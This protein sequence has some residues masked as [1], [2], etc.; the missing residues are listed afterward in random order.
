MAT[1]NA[2]IIDGTLGD[3]IIDALGGRDTIYATQGHDSV[4]GGANLNDRIIAVLADPTRFADPAT[5]SRTYTITNNHLGSSSGGLDTSFV[6]VERV[7]LELGGTGDF[8]DTID[9]T[10]FTGG[11]ALDLRLGNGNDTVFG[12][13][14]NESIYA[15]GGIN[16][17][18][19]GAGTDSVAADVDFAAGSTVFV[20]GSGNQVQT[21]HNGTIT[22]TILNAEQ[23]LIGSNIDLAF[24]VDGLTHTVDASAYIGA[25]QIVFYDH[26]GNDIFIGSSGSDV[27]ANLYNATVG[28]DIYTGNGGADIFDYTV[29]VNALNNDVITDFDTDDTIDFRF[30]DG[31]SAP[32]QL[33]CNSFI[34]AAAFSGVAGQYRYTISGNQT[35][36]QIDTDGDAA[37]DRTL[38]LSNGTFVI[39]ETFAGSN[40]LRLAGNVIQGTAGPDTLTGTSG[41]DTIING[42]GVDTI[43]AGD[44]DDTIVLNAQVGFGSVLDGGNGFDTLELKTQPTFVSNLGG[45]STSYNVYY[46]TVPSSIEAVRFDSAPGDILSIN[47]LEFQR[48]AAGLT[49]LIGGGGRDLFYDIV[50]SP[51][52]YT[53]PQLTLVNWNADISDLNADYIVLYA[54]SAGNYTLNAREGL[55]A[56]QALIGNVGNDVLNGSSGS[57]ALNGMGGVNQLY[58][59]AGNDTLYAENPTPFG[60]SPTALTYAG[61]TFNGGADIDTLVVGGP[62]NFQGTLTSIER[63]YFEAA[64]AAQAPGQ[65]GFDP[66][67]LT[68]STTTA[69]GLPSDLIL[70]G[71]GTLEINLDAPS[72][73]SAAGYAFV[74]GSTVDL[75]LNGTAGDDEIVGSVGADTINGGDGS[76]F[77]RGNVGDDAIY[78]GDG[79]DLIKGQDGDDLIDGGLGTDRAGYYQANAALGGVTVSL[80]L[81]G[82][83]QYVGSQGWDT[84]VS[85]ENVF[86]TPFADV[87]TGDGGNNWL[88]GSEATIDGNVSAINN[89]L[90]DGQGGNDLLSIG[91]GNHTLIGGS[92]NDTVWFTEHGF[93]ETGITVS[94]ASP[95]TVQATG[96]GDWS[97]TGIENLTGG[98]ANDILTG[99]DGVNV[100]GGGAG[101]DT[102]IGGIGNDVLYG[103]GGIAVDAN[104][105]ITTFA[106]VAAINGTGIGA[107]VAMMPG[108]S[109]NDTLEG[110]EGDDV[111]WGGGGSDTA[112]YASASGA[113]EV[114]LYN[115]GFGEAFGAAGYDQLH[116]IENITGSAFNDS[117]FG[118]AL[119]NVLA[120]GDGVDALR[121]NGGNDAL[122]GGGDDDFINGGNGD[123]FINGGS[124][125]DRA[126]YFQ[127]DAALGGI[128]VSLLLQGSAQYVGSQGWD[129]L[130][131]IENVS[132]TPFADI[133]TGDGAD[134]WLWGS[135]SWNGSVQSATNN[136]TIDGGGGND[137]IE[138]GLGNHLLTGG[139][140]NDTV[141]YSE[142]G[143]AEVGITVSLALQGAAQTTGAG[144]WML[145]GI[146][147]LRGGTGNDQLTGDENANV[148]T[149]GGG[150]DQLVGGAGS[151]QAAY[152]GNAADFAVVSLGGGA[153]Q[154][155]DLNAADG[156]EGVDLILGIEQLLFADQ[157]V[158]LNEAPVA[159]ASSFLT[160]EDTDLGGQVA[161]SDLEN[162]PLT[163]QL[164]TGPTNGTLSF[165]PDGTFN[166]TPGVNFFGADSFTFTA[167]DGN[168]TSNVATAD[169]VIAPVDN[170]AATIGG[171]LT[172]ELTEGINPAAPNGTISGQ[173]SAVDPDGPTS[174]TAGNQAGTWGAFTISA[175]GGWSYE[176]ADNDPFIGALKASDTVTD[177][178]TVTTADG[179]S[180]LV[181]VTIHGANDAAVI[182]GTRTA[183]VGE[184]ALLG[185]TSQV[186]GALTISDIDSPSQFVAA[187]LAGLYGTLTLN[188]S[189]SWTYVL[190]NANPV[191]DGLSN[192]NSLSD[193]FTVFAADGT[194]QQ[195]LITVTGS[196]D[197]RTGTNNADVL[198][199]TT[200]NDTLNGNNGNDT[201]GGGLGN[202]VLN[203]GNGIDTA[204]YA[205]LAAGVTVSLEIST[206]Q[207]TLGGGIDT[208]LSIENLTGTNQ[209]DVLTGNSSNNT[210]IGGDGNDVLQGGAGDDILN[211]GNGID[212]ASYVSAGSAVTVSLAVSASQKTGGAGSDTL[213][214]I[215]NLVGSGFADALT[216][217]STANVLTGG[218]GADRLTGGGGADVL[219]GGLGDDVFSFA[220][221]LDSGPSVLAR[222]IISDFQ[223]AGIA[224]GD[225][226]D[227]SAIDAVPGGRDNAFA[228]IGN[229]GFHNVAGELRF[230]TSTPGYTVVQADTNGDGVADLEI[231][232][233]WADSGTPIIPVSTDFVL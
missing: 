3:D 102:L 71:I 46:P 129:T 192:G 83:A 127:S 216:G 217:N 147:N 120:G 25:A 148:L 50:F 7:T 47:M 84:L 193:S 141:W 175:D 221:L 73:F 100:L 122:Y 211:G 227:L 86:G 22:N 150:N 206:A 168:T 19:A 61:S 116:D 75:I 180:S 155:S 62:V 197:V 176:L 48:A 154:V 104:G 181:T 67:H 81:Q 203:G 173:L 58:G 169:L 23:I 28:D 64:F 70:N 231:A 121:G 101:N 42:G 174:F 218:A 37:A 54:S 4:D 8:G 66:A 20:T 36:I 123:D 214:G 59:N 32:G 15:R 57:D 153:W 110:G 52:N 170:D 230:D 79:N 106:D 41:T 202:D 187:T 60:S 17:I 204:T 38:T 219:F 108:V 209:A 63:I 85:I 33:L 195:V 132:G 89:D 232:L 44:G 29:A 55:A 208:L 35:L 39:A 184:A 53:M 131:N 11:F 69:Q 213:T 107:D 182:G 212:T 98:T 167:S 14:G 228:F 74:P 146:E 163:F 80:L 133:L 158:T 172:G 134:N 201:L 97:L 161:A 49:T 171:Q 157:L 105:V 13:A 78:G 77:L 24:A 95:G 76:D 118:N 93:P 220:A 96:N 5:G 125:N 9:A 156:D 210:L 91:I 119:A 51:G 152:T 233:Q 2:D 160:D 142:N 178:F 115:G 137:L 140:D 87:L 149:G 223:G 166:Y 45:T 26:N 151:D 222:D 165:N 128:T 136:D 31:A 112:S 124:G 43:H 186:A 159:T 99:D 34:G 188:A 226:I 27:F 189:G 30:N 94:L 117:L 6:N 162:A 225:I 138:V 88:S 103:D 183:A 198:S 135:I 92:D 199:G 144:S 109:G 12:G 200:G 215:E 177:S 65:T 196:D 114:G 18:D 194:A 224:G 111:L 130:V 56:I 207:N 143:G 82:T 164:V 229:A 185:G 40:V 16:W 205:G 179:S 113:V 90:L 10:S 1:N 190:N 72:W 191:V 21:V 126:A 139:A 68:L 145:S